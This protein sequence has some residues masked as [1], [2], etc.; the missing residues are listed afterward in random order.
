[1]KA[2]Q[3]FKS[4]TGT[5][6]VVVALEDGFAHV[7]ITYFDGN[8]VSHKL[9]IEI[10]QDIIKEQ[11]FKQISTTPKAPR[12]AITKKKNNSRRK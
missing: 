6:L 11:G 1:M 8:T 7:I 9:P 5:T 4:K 12:K 3:V 10:A 2:G